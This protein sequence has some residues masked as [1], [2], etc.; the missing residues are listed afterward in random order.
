[1]FG[2][3]HELMRDQGRHLHLHKVA[4]A[5]VIRADDVHCQLPPRQRPVSYSVDSLPGYLT[6]DMS[7]TAREQAHWLSNGKRLLPATVSDRQ[8]VDATPLCGLPEVVACAHTA[9]HLRMVGAG[10]RLQRR[11]HVLGRRC[12]HNF[13]HLPS[14]QTPNRACLLACNNVSFLPS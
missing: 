8:E 1:M 9:P 5:P 13:I 4:C 2:K 7:L 11:Q 10:E 14:Q 3:V 12:A 6:L